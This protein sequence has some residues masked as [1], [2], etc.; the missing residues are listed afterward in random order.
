M[1]ATP[2]AA[3]APGGAGESGVLAEASATG[4]ASGGVT[5]LP[6]YSDLLVEFLPFDRS[7]LE[8]AIDRFLNRF[9][10]LGAE[11]TELS[12]PSG[13]VPVVVATALAAVAADFTLRKQRGRD[14]AKE[15]SAED[16]EGELARCAGIP[17]LWR[18]EES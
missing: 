11:L 5:P 16:P 1:R 4:A 12:E 8:N 6:Q 3:A 18:L 15:E 9:E 13:A 2:A 7:T 14:D 17:I 10:N